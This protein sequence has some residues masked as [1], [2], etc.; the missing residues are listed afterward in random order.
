MCFIKTKNKKVN[1]AKLFIALLRMWVLGSISGRVVN[2][3]TD[4][5]LGSGCME[6]RAVYISHKL[7]QNRHRV[8]IFL[9]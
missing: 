4:L 2:I 6:L 7:H 8:V 3:L 9:F 5:A 1:N